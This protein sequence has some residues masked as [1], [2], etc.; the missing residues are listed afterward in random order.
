[1]GFLE[2]LDRE[3]TAAARDTLVQTYAWANSTGYGRPSRELRERAEAWAD[4]I[5]ARGKTAEVLIALS[6]P[7]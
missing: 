5:E 2:E 1:M 3:V 7:D 4:D 6:R